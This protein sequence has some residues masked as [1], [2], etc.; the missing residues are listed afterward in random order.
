MSADL[1]SRTR[2]L[3]V[4]QGTTGRL[5]FTH[6]RPDNSPINITGEKLRFIVSGSGCGSAFVITSD[7]PRVDPVGS[8][9]YDASLP[10][11]QSSIVI[12]DAAAGKWSLTLSA[13]MTASI[14]AGTHQYE[15]DKIQADGS[16][17]TYVCG[18][19]VVIAHLG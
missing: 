1:S 19:F 5:D 10:P 15:I 13:V 4:R 7:A 16:T 17:E 2:T 8:N 6:K 11:T 14:P 18:E 3:T 12:T 9:P